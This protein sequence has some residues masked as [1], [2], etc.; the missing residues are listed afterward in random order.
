MIRV[1][2]GLLCFVGIVAQRGCFA[3][4]AE[5]VVRE[6]QEQ[7]C[8]VN[9]DSAACAAQKQGRIVDAE[10]TGEAEAVTALRRH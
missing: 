8:I 5:P 7:D 3:M 4:D 2:L 6:A 1:G 10:F 9:A